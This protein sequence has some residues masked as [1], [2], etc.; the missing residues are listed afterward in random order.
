MALKLARIAGCKVILT[1]SS[2]TKLERVR[3]FRNI[4]HVSTIN[5][6]TI[7]DWDVE[8]TRLNGG[9]GVDI[10]IENGGTSSLLKSLNATAKRGTV[11]QVGYLGIQNT[12]DLEGLLEV[13]VDRTVTLKYVSFCPSH[14]ER[15]LNDLGVSMLDPDWISRT[16]AK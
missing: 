8:A 14:L 3:S 1:S 2:D 6:K 5:Y 7:S 15:E 9:V 12:D 11:S 10:V 4:G 13:L 16:C